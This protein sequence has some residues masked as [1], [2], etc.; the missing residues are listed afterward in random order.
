MV[1]PRG[2]ATCQQLL[3]GYAWA[4]GLDLRPERLAFLLTALE[5]STHLV[6]MPKVVGDDGIDIRKNQ[7][8]VGADHVFR[9]HAIFVMVNDQIETDSAVANTDSAS[10]IQP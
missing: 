5:V 1:F 2:I 7:S 3:P 9:R 8:I 10:L 4:L 6:T